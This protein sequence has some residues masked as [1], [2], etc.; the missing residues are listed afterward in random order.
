[1]EI[2]NALVDDDKLVDFTF[3]QKAN[4]SPDLIYQFDFPLKITNPLDSGRV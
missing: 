3:E 4:I 2:N 1:M